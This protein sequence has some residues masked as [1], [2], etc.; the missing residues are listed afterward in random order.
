MLGYEGNK[1]SYNLTETDLQVMIDWERSRAASYRLSD[2]QDNVDIVVGFIRSRF[3]KITPESLDAAVATNF[4]SLDYMTG[5]EHPVLRAELAQKAKDAADKAQAERDKIELDKKRK[6]HDQIKAGIQPNQ[7]K[8]KTEFDRDE[9]TQK[10]AQDAREAAEK[11]AFKQVEDAS[12]EE[13]ERLR[14]GYMVSHNGG[15]TNW[16]RTS[17]RRDLLKA[18]RVSKKDGTILWTETLRLI[19]NCLHGF[20]I[21]DSKRVS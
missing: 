17:E 13:V 12:R 1:M 9:G 3:G 16:A 19:K 6:L 20:E 2:K 21:E 8:I 7:S 18:T 5:Q 15:Q 10:R 4:R 14:D 11:A